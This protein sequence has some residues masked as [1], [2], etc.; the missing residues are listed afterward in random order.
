MR[1]SPSLCLFTLHDL[2]YVAV[3]PR[4]R[5][6]AAS[7]VLFSLSIPTF[8]YFLVL[9]V[10]PVLQALHFSGVFTRS[11]LQ[12]FLPD[13]PPPRRK[14]NQPLMSNPSCHGALPRY[15]TAVVSR[16]P[17]LWS[18]CMDAVHVH[19]FVSRHACPRLETFSHQASC[20]HLRVNGASQ[21]GI[22]P[23]P[24]RDD[25]AINR[26]SPDGALPRS[27]A[28][29]VSLPFC[30]VTLTIAVT[31]P[32]FALFVTRVVPLQTLEQRSTHLSTA[33]SLPPAARQQEL[34]N[35]CTACACYVLTPKP[36]NPFFCVS[37][38]STWSTSSA[39]AHCTTG[40]ILR[41]STVVVL[42]PRPHHRHRDTPPQ[43]ALP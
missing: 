12:A 17:A 36:Q 25:S 7:Q 23:F 6:V 35:V 2:A 15:S 29:V 38:Q 18:L 32:R 22:T 20:R 34:V 10:P 40:C 1:P 27:R 30:C 4:S 9:T 8:A 37:A 21:S 42:W 28:C 14:N 13:L 39:P 3:L 5:R 24:N 26:V 43:V 16:R 41:V 31:N 11:R 33:A 19:I